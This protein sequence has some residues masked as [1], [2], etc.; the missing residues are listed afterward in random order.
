MANIIL[1]FGQQQWGKVTPLCSKPLHLR[2]NISTRFNSSYLGQFSCFFLPWQW[3]LNS[4]LMKSQTKWYE[5]TRCITWFHYVTNYLKVSWVVSAFRAVISRNYPPW[6]WCM[7]NCDC[8]L[9]TNICLTLHTDSLVTIWRVCLLFGTER[10]SSWDLTITLGHNRSL[11]HIG[12][13]C[14][15]MCTKFVTESIVNCEEL[16]YLRL[17]FLW[18]E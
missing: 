14:P 8:T 18:T 6:G 15:Q 1:I 17:Y 7:L 12:C 13:F 4:L 2:M 10:V 5:I 3:C 11:T 9:A 16:S